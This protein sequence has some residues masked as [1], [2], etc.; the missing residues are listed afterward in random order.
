LTRATI[1]EVILTLKGLLQGCDFPS[2]FAVTL[3]LF[4]SGVFR[5][6]I[7]FVEEFDE[8]AGFCNGFMEQHGKHQNNY[9]PI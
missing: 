8:G 2:Q 7:G 4:L 9:K 3:Q 1:R 6:E 5:F